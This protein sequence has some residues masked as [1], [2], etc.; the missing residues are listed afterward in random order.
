M[1]YKDGDKVKL[2]VNE[3]VMY[4]C[5]NKCLQNCI[6]RINRHKTFT[7]KEK[8]NV[9]RLYFEDKSSMCLLPEIHL[10]PAMKWI[11]MK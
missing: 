9:Y 11:R 7:V 10:K 1:K 5:L 2:L 3:D 4:Y 6:I 8:A